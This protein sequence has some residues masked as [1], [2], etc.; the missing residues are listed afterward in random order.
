MKDAILD[1][2]IPYTF[3]AADKYMREIAPTLG[4]QTSGT[5]PKVTM[6]GTSPKVTM[7]GT[8]PK[9]TKK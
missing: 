2:K 7:E 8:S 3:E 1:G 4:L 9:V 5:S 6:E